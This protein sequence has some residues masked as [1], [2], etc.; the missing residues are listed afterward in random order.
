VL[1]DVDRRANDLASDVARLPCGRLT[2]KPAR[3]LRR[4]ASTARDMHDPAP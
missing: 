1:H 2:A 3:S 4:F